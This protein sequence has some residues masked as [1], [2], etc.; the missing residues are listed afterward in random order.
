[1]NISATDIALASDRVIKKSPVRETKDG[2]QLRRG[3][4]QMIS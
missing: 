2:K 4:E 3:D 1:M